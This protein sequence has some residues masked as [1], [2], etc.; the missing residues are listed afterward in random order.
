M[1]RRPQRSVALF[2]IAEAAGQGEREPFLTLGEEAL[3]GLAAAGVVRDAELREDDV[4]QHHL[5]SALNLAL[6]VDDLGLHAHDI[7]VD[8]R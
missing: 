7:A 5:V 4:M 2:A 1:Y 8:A 3:G 6:R